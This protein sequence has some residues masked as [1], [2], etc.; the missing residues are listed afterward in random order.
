MSKLMFAFIICIS[1]VY[2]KSDPGFVS[3]TGNESWLIEINDS[4][5]VQTNMI[6]KLPSGSYKFKARPQISYSWPAILIEDTFEIQAADTILFSLRVENSNVT[7]LP[8]QMT[9]KITAY[10]GNG[11][12]PPIIKDTRLKTGLIISAF[13]ANWLSF[14]LKRQADD[15]Y[16]KYKSS[17]NGSK[18]N[19]YF[20][21]SNKLDTYSSIALGIS[22]AALSSYIYL[23]LTD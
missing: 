18:I 6:T 19:D 14:Y 2:A 23:T 4:L 12:Q 15:Y 1:S 7:T 8:F 9:P 11:Y 3:F 22:A 16:H 13:A 17:S 5:T 21:K 20:D 10:S